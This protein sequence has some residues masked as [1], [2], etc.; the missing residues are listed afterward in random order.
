M[1]DMSK[2]IKVRFHLQRGVNYMK[3]QVRNGN[4]VSYYNPEEFSLQ[5]FDCQLI[6]KPNVAKKIYEG[7]HKTVCA[8]ILCK[9]IVILEHVDYDSENELRFNPRITPN[10]IHDN[11][12]VDSNSYDEIVTVKNKVYFKTK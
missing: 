11:N 6:N 7:S 10:W 9:K 2:E 3:W 12:N 5:L 4:N 8:W 1:K